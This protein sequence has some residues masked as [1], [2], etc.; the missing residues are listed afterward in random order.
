MNSVTVMNEKHES[1]EHF[2]EM[3]NE[4]IEALSV[5]SKLLIVDMGGSGYGY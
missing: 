1:L 4:T 3:Q 5:H 2:L